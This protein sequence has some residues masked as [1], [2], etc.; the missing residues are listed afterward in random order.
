MNNLE[1]KNEAKEVLQQLL[2]SISILSLDDYT[3]KNEM[4]V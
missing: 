2:N 1:L 4:Y 3:N